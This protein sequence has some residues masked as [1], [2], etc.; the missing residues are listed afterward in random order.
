M[1][2]AIHWFRRDLR[3]RDN[4]ALAEAVV[5][6]DGA[7]LPLFILDDAILRAPDTAPAR[8][9]LLLDALA[10]LDKQLRALGS[11]LV[12]RRGPSIPTLR[13]I[14]TSSAAATVCWNADHTPFSR[15][16]DAAAS[17]MLAELGVGTRVVQEAML[18]GADEL[19]SGAG[20][21]YTI[22]TPYARRWR[23]LVAAQSGR[24]DA[25]AAP[26]RLAPLSAAIADLPLP[27]I[28]ALGVTIDQ[29]LPTGG[30][31][32]GYERLA[33]FIRSRAADNYTAGR[34]LLAEP[35]T[36]RLSPYL[37]L[38]CVAPAAALRLALDAIDRS[39]PERAA[40]LTTW[41]GELAW[42]DFYYQ[43]MVNFPH[44]LATAFKPAYADLAWENDES[45]FAAW[46]A[47]HT[48][49]PI[50]DAAMRQLAAEAWM[51]NRGRMIVASFLTKDLLIDWRWGERFFMRRLVDGDHASNNG[52][53]QWAAGTGTDAQPYF[54]IFN[55]VSQGEKFD[56][57]GS[58]IRRYIPELADV[59]L[60]Y[61]HAPWTM[62]PAEAGRIGF[63]LGRDYPHPLVD[64]ALQR[65]RALALYK[66]GTEPAG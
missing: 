49:Y 3:L 53:W 12:V 52:G 18:I 14:A 31:T 34:N 5:R 20:T 64:H 32:P 65:A 60:R 30:E 54:R 23:E 11:R 39:P 6:S 1:T 9:A 15:R 21:P 26:Q 27:S 66:R 7:V 24:F 63:A 8:V 4:P 47:G 57:R 56:P 17:A 43:I 61:L 29:A 28:A 19:R 33:I 22:Y 45:L 44:V 2:L 55:P 13:E 41:V 48:G 36:S 40:G 51:H 35:G 16:R 25:I 46:C 37:H 50:V 59:P 62:P 58:Y 38:G 10:D 42:R